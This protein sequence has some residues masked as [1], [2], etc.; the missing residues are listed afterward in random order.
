[1]YPRTA[2]GQILATLSM[3]CG[4]LVIA[5]PVTVIGQNFSTIY[6]AMEKRPRGLGRGG[7]ADQVGIPEAPSM[8]NGRDGRKPITKHW[9]HDLAQPWD[10][11]VTYKEFLPCSRRCGPPSRTPG[12]R[13]CRSG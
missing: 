9:L 5:L 8:D 4:I 2:A 1:M 10:I 3:L 11:D 13:R 6:S 12:R 7:G